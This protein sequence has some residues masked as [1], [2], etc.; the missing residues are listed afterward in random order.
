MWPFLSSLLRFSPFPY[1]YSKYVS[2]KNNSVTIIFF[3]F[4]LNNISHILS[5]FLVPGILSN[6]CFRLRSAS[7]DRMIF[8][9]CVHF[10]LSLCIFIAVLFYF[11]FI[12]L[13]LL[14]PSCLF[15]SSC[16]LL[17]FLTVSCINFSFDSFPFVSLFLI[18][19]DEYKSMDR[20]RISLLIIRTRVRCH[21]LES[22]V[23]TE[24]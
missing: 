19:H 21:R 20:P 14:R 13:Y 7:S 8:F 6:I 12:Y 5:C 10:V 17:W 11:Y 22:I 18:L 1:S 2:L 23:V 9:I 4:A 15:S 16:F 24:C 3:T